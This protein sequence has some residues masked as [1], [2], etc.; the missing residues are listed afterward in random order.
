[1][2]VTVITSNIISPEITDIIRRDAPTDFMVDTNQFSSVYD[3]VFNIST[4]TAT[5]TYPGG[6]IIWWSLFNNR[7]DVLYVDDENVSYAIE[8]ALSSLL[9]N[10]KSIQCQIYNQSVG[11][12]SM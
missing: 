11:R 5:V 8:Q 6:G 3:G 4:D 2:T 10:T 9:L 7:R 12:R 1:M